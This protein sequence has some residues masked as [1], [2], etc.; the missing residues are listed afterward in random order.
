[1]GFCDGHL[2]LRV[3]FSKFIQTGT[4]ISTSFLSIAKKYSIACIY[5]ISSVDGHLGC[6]SV[7]AIVN[8]AAMKI[9]VHVFFL[10][11]SFIWVYALE[12]DCWII[13]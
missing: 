5:Y 3:M 11:Y 2:S 4:C 10:N 7:S 9:G 13:W 1:M 6:F 8:S 12:W